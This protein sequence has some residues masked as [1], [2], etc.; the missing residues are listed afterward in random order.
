MRGFQLIEV[1]IAGFIFFLV[2]IFLLNLLPSS[3]WAVAKAEMRLTA[4]NLAHSKL[5]ELRTGPFSALALGPHT[6]PVHQQH[7][8]DFETSFEVRVLADADPDLVKDVEVTVRWTD[9]RQPREL[10]ARG[11]IGR[12]RR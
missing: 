10:R 4:E 1:I 2:S 5:E 11:Y 9:R 12:L 6:A 7:G 8:V 3:Q